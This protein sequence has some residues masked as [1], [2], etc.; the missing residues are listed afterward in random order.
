MAQTTT[1]DQRLT[2]L[3]QKYASVLTMIQQQGIRLSHVH[4]QDDKLFI[5]GVASSENAKNAVWTQ[6]KA[7][8]PQY[9][10][11]TADITVEASSNA[12]SPAASGGG[13]GS[14]QSYTVQSGDTLSKISK[15]F[16]GDANQYMKIFEANKGKL[17][18]PDKIQ[19][20]Q[21]LTIPSK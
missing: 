3:K 11:I 13:Q 10:D 15:Q 9:N 19:V 12:G 6:I 14:G 16:Y 7:I 18:D 4:V 8:N 21:V 5:Q 2:E 17:T 1:T 20:G